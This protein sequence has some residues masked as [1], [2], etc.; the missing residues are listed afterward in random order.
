[1]DAD[2][3]LSFI[4][5]QVCVA[6]PVNRDLFEPRLFRTIPRRPVCPSPS[7]SACSSA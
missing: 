1:M 3:R 7:G 5:S 2:I 4:A 6:I